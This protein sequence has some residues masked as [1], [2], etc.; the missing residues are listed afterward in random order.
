MSAHVALQ[1]MRSFTRSTAMCTPPE[2]S[3]Y[4][5]HPWLQLRFVLPEVCDVPKVPLNPF[6]G[7]DSVKITFSAV[8]KNECAG[9]AP[10]YPI[11]HLFYRHHHCPGRAASENSLAS[12]EAATTHDTVQVRHSHTLVSQVGAKKLGA[13]G[14]AVPRNEALGRL[15]AKDHAPVSINREDLGAQVVISNVFGAAS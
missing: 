15:S 3:R 7:I 9:C 4:G 14:R 8:V 10:R 12:H 6:V 13:S 5:H 2:K 11:L 1:G